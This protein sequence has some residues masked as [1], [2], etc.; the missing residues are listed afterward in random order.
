[1]PVVHCDGEPIEVWLPEGQ[2]YPTLQDM[3]TIRTFQRECKAILA[4]GLILAM[5]G[6][7]YVRQ[8]HGIPR[9]WLRAYRPCS[10][11]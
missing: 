6:R 10:N 8:S 4:D 11:G 7:N 3:E 2:R 1:M 5:E 9:M